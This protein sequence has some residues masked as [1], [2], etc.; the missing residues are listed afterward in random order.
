M[1]RVFIRLVAFGAA[2]WLCVYPLVLV[3]AGIVLLVGTGQGR[4]LLDWTVHEAQRASHR[5]FFHGSVLAW[6]AATW[7]SSRVLLERR[8]EPPFVN[9]SL[10]SPERYALRLRKWMPRVLGVLV[11]PPL[12]AYF[13]LAGNAAHAAVVAGSGRRGGRSW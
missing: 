6:S 8:F 12:A 2:C 11:Y 9:M 1:Q 13:A 3:L 7:Y 4:E 5:Y 10:A